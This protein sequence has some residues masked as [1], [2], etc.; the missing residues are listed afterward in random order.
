[1]IAAIV[2]APLL[3]R[4]FGSSSNAAGHTMYLSRR[5]LIIFYPSDTGLQVSHP[6]RISDAAVTARIL[7]GHFV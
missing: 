2:V 7:H 3:G 4:I 6:P 5:Q 1:M